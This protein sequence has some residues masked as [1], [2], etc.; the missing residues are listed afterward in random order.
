MSKLAYSKN[1]NNH[2]HWIDMFTYLM[3]KVGNGYI[4][5]RNVFIWCENQR[6]IQIISIYENNIV[7]CHR[8][9]MDSDLIVLFIGFFFHC[10]TDAPHFLRP[11]RMPLGSVDSED[12]N[13]LVDDELNNLLP[14]TRE[15]SADDLSQVLNIPIK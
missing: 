8:I 4:T 11:R 1:C 9:H 14:G 12:G 13:A 7:I 6:T 15:V 2:A 10:R 3:F 5:F